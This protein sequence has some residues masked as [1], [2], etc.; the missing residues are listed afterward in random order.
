MESKEILKNKIKV[1]RA[2]KSI[3]QETLA[4]A[5]GVSRQAIIAIE[6][7]KYV[8]STLLALKIANYF[9]VKFEEV[10]WIDQS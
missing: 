1:L 8:P 2:E 5:V 7:S 4:E 9:G 3:S 6:S 10:F